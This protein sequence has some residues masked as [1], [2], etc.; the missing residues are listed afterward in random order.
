MNF[1][2][3][4]IAISKRKDITMCDDTKELDGSHSSICVYLPNGDI[5]KMRWPRGDGKPAE[6]DKK[7][8]DALGVPETT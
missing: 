5:G 2:E 4:V 8:E 6:V 7:V 3:A 1:I